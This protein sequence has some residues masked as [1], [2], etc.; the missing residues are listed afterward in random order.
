[1]C[2]VCK[3]S[4]FISGMNPWVLPR[5]D[6]IKKVG[7]TDMIRKIVEI[8]KE[9]CN[10]CG[11]CINA[12]HEG[13]L[14]L[15]DGK[16]ELVSDEY[17]DGLGDCLPECPTGAI[18]IIEREAVPYDEVSV[19]KRQAELQA[20]EKAANRLSPCSCPGTREEMLKKAQVSP[21]GSAAESNLD[22]DQPSELTNWPVQLNLVNPG[23][24][25][26]KDADLLIAA[27][28]TAF[29]YGAFHNKFMKGKVTLIGCP[30]LDD[31]DYYM[32]K[33]TEIL[34]NNTPKSITVVRMTVPCC[35]GIVYA[36]KESM[37]RAKKV[38]PYSEVIISPYGE[39]VNN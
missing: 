25:Y 33:I 38:V 29:A 37:L 21:K 36:V 27:D 39:I 6:S 15:V 11:L 2:S 24:S 23:A 34:R 13:A 7:E 28:C 1:M 9:K 16:A 18:K 35:S 31:N 26:L 12:C 32:E 19:K 5:A 3:K 10:G 8:D 20:E 22:L 14:Q 17:C 4:A 30:K